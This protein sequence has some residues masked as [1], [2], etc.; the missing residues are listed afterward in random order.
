MIRFGVDPKAVIPTG[1]PR[2]DSLPLQEPPAVPV[3]TMLGLAEEEILVLAD[4]QVGKREAIFHMV[5][6]A[7]K[8]RSQVGSGGETP[9]PSR[10]S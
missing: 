5:W 3:R 1:C 2:F 4:Q 9:P 8:K 7:V 10:K 6:E